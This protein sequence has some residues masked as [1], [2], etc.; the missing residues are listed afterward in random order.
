MFSKLFLAAAFTTALTSAAP[1]RANITFPFRAGSATVAAGEY[2]VTRMEN[3]APVFS[4]RD[5]K[6]GRGVFVM[7]QYAS[8]PAKGEARPRLV[9][10]CN[11][12]VCGLTEIWIG[13]GSSFVTHPRYTRGEQERMVTVYLD[14]VAGE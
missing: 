10:S 6:T 8:A 4:L 13:T 9:F 1:M 12:T 5:N 14:K 2:E 11:S 7:A 3:A